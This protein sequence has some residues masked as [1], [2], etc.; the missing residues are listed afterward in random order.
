MKWTALVLCFSLFFQK[1]AFAEEKKVE[2]YMPFYSGTLLAIDSRCA[3]P[4]YVSLQP[5]FVLM[6]EN[7]TYNGDRKLVK[8]FPTNKAILLTSITTGI[9]S[10]LD[11]G[12]IFLG[13]Y[14]C[15]LGQEN[16]LY[17]DTQVF[18]SFQAARDQ[19][20]TW[21][22]DIKFLLQES[23][24]TGKYQNL[25]LAK[26]RSDISG[27]GAYETSLV[28]ITRKIFYLFPQHPFNFSLN[29]SY[30]LPSNVPVKNIN[31]YK[32]GPGL[33]GEV[34]PGQQFIANLGTEFSVT[35]NWVLG[36]DIHYLHRDRAVAKKT[37]QPLY[38][39]GLPSTDEI[40]LAPCLEY[41]FSPFSSITGAL[42]FPVSSRNST[43]FF[44]GICNV[45]IYF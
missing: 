4:G 34:S 40:S 8:A 32:G 9:T 15:F 35:Q 27:T 1:I 2:G 29:L 42:W 37:N 17:G 21:I 7:G 3:A 14:T 19:K 23:F 39:L 45:Y 38:P 20:G 31:V 24:P 11:I 41:N 30:V 13:G 10:F 28:F 33:E 36:L 6:R 26:G 44:A 12:V 22:P 43:S 18:V 16:L 25:K 5:F